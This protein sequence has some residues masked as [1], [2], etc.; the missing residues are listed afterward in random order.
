M[1]HRHAL[2]ADLCR[3]H[4]K[5]TYLGLHVK[6]PIYLFDFDQIWSSLTG[7]FRSPQLSNFMEIRL[8][9]VTLLHADRRAEEETERQTDGRRDRETDGLM[10]MTKLTGVFRDCAK[11]STNDLMFCSEITSLLNII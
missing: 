7:F 11:A 9:V 10:Y 5:I 8:V 6:C 1:L 3:R 2:M 4:K